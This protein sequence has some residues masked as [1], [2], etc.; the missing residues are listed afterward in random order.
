MRIHNF[1]AGPC[2][3]PLEVLEEARDEF[4]DYHG[5]GA[6]L[7]EMSHRSPEYE[8]V[9]QAALATARRLAQ[10]PDDFEVL[11]L[12]GGASLQF[13]MV[14]MNLL[15]HG[16]T[17]GY[18]LTGSWSKKAY[19]DARHHGDV[20]VAWDGAEV[21][22]AR[23]PEAT[24]LDPPAFARYLHLCSNETIGGI[25]WP[26]WPNV[27]VPLVVDMSSEFLARPIPWDLVDVVY[28]GVQKNLGPAGM[29][30]VFVRRSVL[31]A[32]ADLAAYLNWATHAAKDSLY[33]TPPVFVVWMTGKVLAWLEEQGGVAALEERAAERAGR[34]YEAID[35][36]GGYYRSPVD[37]A[38]RSHMNVVF[39]LPTE[40]D[41]ARFLAGA[42]ERGLANLK[43]H[44]SVGGIRASVYAAMPMEG[45]DA[46]VDHMETFAR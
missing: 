29:S 46:L 44:R 45:V 37:V 18:A 42:A 43:G 13:A 33:N 27:G 26:D 25:R 31:D 30:I 10:V 3:L 6:S 41:E 38:H 40:E 39:R 35:G 17:A 2:T 5:A 8:A 9:H 32:D 36:S 23:T 4:V 22:Y 16:D 7:I 28:G 1:S 24:E 12:Q 21:G 19:D 20:S 34:L 15:D 11:F 14:P